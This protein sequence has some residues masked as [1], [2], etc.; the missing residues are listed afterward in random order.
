[1]IGDKYVI[2]SQVT[3]TETKRSRIAALITIQVQTEQ[4]DRHSHTHTNTQARN[5]QHIIAQLVVAHRSERTRN[6]NIW[7]LDSPVTIHHS[8]GR[9]LSVGRAAASNGGES[10]ICCCC[11]VADC[12]HSCSGREIAV[13]RTEKFKQNKQNTDTHAN[14]RCII[15]MLFREPPTVR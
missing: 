2:L 9:L 7:L 1:M 12:G 3:T 6:M 5:D 15:A 8:F 13:H 14:A 10:M 11:T 4:H